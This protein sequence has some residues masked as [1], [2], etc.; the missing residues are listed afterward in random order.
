M[1]L[2]STIVAAACMFVAVA[3]ALGASSEDHKACISDDGDRVVASCTRIIE[4]KQESD[5]AR[6]AAFVNRAYGWKLREERS[7]ALA[8]LDEA[9]RLNPNDALAYNN[10][11]IIWREK[12]E[13]DNA[14]VDFTE[15]IRINPQ[16]RSDTAASGNINVYTNRGLAWQ[17]KEELDRALADFDEAIKLDARDVGAWYRRA[18]VR[19]Q[20]EQDEQAIADLTVVVGL[21][22]TIADAWYRRGHLLFRRYV[23]QSE[24]IRKEDLDRAIEDFGEVIRREPGWPLGFHLRGLAYTV[25]GERERALND[26]L[27]AIE[28]NPHNPEVLAAVK[29]LKP[30]YEVPKDPLEKLM[31]WDPLP[32]ATKK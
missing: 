2:H 12:R 27:V 6:G 17:A 13:I 31:K 9:I 8:D 18:E 24:W 10:R 20:K 22:P 7:R 21:D 28:L 4:D 1:R 16:P 19:I 30:D 25:K 23:S 14:I 5:K 11:G 3:P 15:A 32:T 26:L 29:E